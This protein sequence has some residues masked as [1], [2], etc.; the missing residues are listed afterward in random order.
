MRSQFDGLRSIL[1]NTPVPVVDAP[2]VEEPPVAD[3]P[4]DALADLP[5]LSDLD[6]G[7][8]KGDSKAVRPDAAAAFS[9]LAAHADANHHP[10]NSGVKASAPRMMADEPERALSTWTAV[11]VMAFGLVLG[12]SAA[13]ALFHDDVTQILA[14]W[15]SSSSSRPAR[16]K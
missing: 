14:A 13:M 16:G 2:A 7:L 5:D 15:D 8:Y 11:A 6:R 10:N 9:A 3:T 12:G 4:V 1:G